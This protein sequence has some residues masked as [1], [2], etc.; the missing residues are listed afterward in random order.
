MVPYGDHAIS[1]FNSHAEEIDRKFGKGFFGVRLV[2]LNALSFRVEGKQA[3]A[4]VRL[5]YL[6]A[7]DPNP[8][9]QWMS[10]LLFMVDIPEKQLIR[11][12]TERGGF[13]NRRLR[14]RKLAIQVAQAHEQQG[15]VDGQKERIDRVAQGD[16]RKRIEHLSGFVEGVVPL[17]WPHRWVKGLFLPLARNRGRRKSLPTMKQQEETNA[18]LQGKERMR[19]NRDDMQRFKAHMGK[20]K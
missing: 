3:L 19:A 6:Q 11:Q 18:H 1:L 13:W 8:V 10:D 15:R 4:S 14:K 9:Y 5:D 2:R 16:F 7:T 20:P 17:G 12:A